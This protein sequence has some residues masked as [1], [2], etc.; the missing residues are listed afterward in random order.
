MY[1]PLGT[2]DVDLTGILGVLHTAGYD[3]W[4][5]MEQDTILSSPEQADAALAD[6][7]ASLAFLTGVLAS[8]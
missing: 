8:A 6:V 1:V 3:G 2:G 4:Y 5:V 7:S